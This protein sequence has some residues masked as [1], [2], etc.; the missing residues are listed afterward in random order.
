MKI[1]LKGKSIIKKVALALAGVCAITAVG[2]GVKAIVDYTKNDLKTIS[3]SFEVGNLGA[4]GKY[5]NDESTLYTKNAFTCD[6]LQIKLDFD[7]EINYQIYY[8]DDLDNFIE[9]TEVLS[10]SYSGGVHD[11][12]ARVVIIPT[13]DEDNKI[14]LKEKIT[15]PNQMTVKVNKEQKSEYVDFYKYRIRT[16]DALGQLRFRY[17]DFQATENDQ[18]IFVESTKFAVNSVDL[19]KVNS[20]KM[21][22]KDISTYTLNIYCFEFGEKDGNIYFINKTN[23]RGEFTVALNKETKYCLFLY[24]TIGSDGVIDIPEKVVSNTL[25]HLSITYSTK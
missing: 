11:G 3:P 24:Q 22:F 2:F 14:S 18:F 13:N 8:Y 7:N 9:S 17:G 19:F 25:S 12:Y 20:G 6:G 15:Y 5:V 23:Q 21:T 10:E 4:D 16:V 1:S